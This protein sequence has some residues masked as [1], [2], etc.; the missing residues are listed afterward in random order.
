MDFSLLW[1]P[2]LVALLDW[3]AVARQWQ[4]LEYITKPGVMLAIL[5]WMGGAYPP[6]ANLG[7]WGWFAA[8]IGLSLLGDIFLVLPNEKFIAGL[9]A[10]LLAHIAYIIGLNL[11]PPPGDWVAVVLLLM[12]GGV[13]F[14]IY[15]RLA[16]ALAEKSQGV[17]Q[18]PVLAYSLVIGV[19]LLSALL[20][21]VREE[22]AAASALS[23]CGG[24]FLFF[25][26][27]TLLAWNRF[28]YPIPNGKLKVRI[29]YHLGQIALVVGA[30]MHFLG[31]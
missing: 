3:I 2:L 14:R 18:K 9:V 28:V 15:R 30:G 31:G 5:G 23:V 27:D 24:A 1:L 25:V 11:A 21:L 8:G 17:L 26:S 13:W 6:G 4:A 7:A 16:A 10:F 12:V 29:T 22:W 19:M 20:T